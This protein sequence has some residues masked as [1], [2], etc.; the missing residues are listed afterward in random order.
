MEIAADHDD[1][2]AD[3]AVDVEAAA[4]HHRGIG[5]FLIALDAH[6]LRD[7]NAGAGQPVGRGVR[8]LS[9]RRGWNEQT[10]DRD[11]RERLA[12]WHLSPY[13]VKT[14]PGVP[15]PRVSRPSP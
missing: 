4:N 9:D 13:D 2:V 6:V 3:A 14:A 7:G 15:T 1:A 8:G 12:H 11:Q 5:H 10:D